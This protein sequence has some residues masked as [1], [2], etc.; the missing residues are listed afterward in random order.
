M[1]YLDLVREKNRAFIDVCE[2]MKKLFDEEVLNQVGRI[3]EHISKRNNWKHWRE[4]K[5][6][7]LKDKNLKKHG[8]YFLAKSSEIIYE[9]I[10]G[11][12]KN[13]SQKLG[14]RIKNIFPKI[15]PDERKRRIISFY[16]NIYVSWYE[17]PDDKVKNCPDEV[18]FRKKIENFFILL[19]NPKYNKE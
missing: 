5:G 7:R 9:G 8:I 2:V 12:K 10:A 19:F 17:V 16:S 15:K 14:E 6:K 3:L 11:N 1:L 18:S 13:S 4:I